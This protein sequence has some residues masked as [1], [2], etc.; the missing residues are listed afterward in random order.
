MACSERFFSVFTPH[1]HLAW[2][3]GQFPSPSIFT[4]LKTVRI[5]DMVDGYG[6][7]LVPLGMTQT[8]FSLLG[9]LSL[10]SRMVGVPP[11][12]SVLLDRLHAPHLKNS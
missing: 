3:Y 4:H 7:S 8:A 11:P 6:S 12:L 9:E 5:T 10:E 2:P 1:T